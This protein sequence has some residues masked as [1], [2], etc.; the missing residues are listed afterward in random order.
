[1]MHDLE[2]ARH[3]VAEIDKQII[4]LIADRLDVVADL[5]KIKK[6]LNIPLRDW[7]VEKRVLT[8]VTDHAK[9]RGIS[10]ELARATLQL[11]IE[12]SRVRQEKLH[13]SGHRG[14]A[15]D[16]LIIG[17]AGTMGRWF[18]DFFLDQGH[19]VWVYDV[20]EES[21]D[22]P[23]VADLDTGLERTSLALIA[24]PLHT[25]PQT[26]DKLARYRFE[27]TV[28]DIASL[29]GHIK[30]SIAAAR[31]ANLSVASI[32]PMFGGGARTLS[33][34]VICCCDCGD[35]D[36]LTHV[37]SLFRNTAANLV[38]LTLDEH[39]EIISYVLGLSHLINVLF[40]TTLKNSGLSYRDLE[41]IGSTTFSSQMRTTS[42]VIRE[43]PDLYYDI[44]HLNPFTPQRLSGL[45]VALERIV[46]SI[47]EEQP[48]TFSSIMNAA[49]AWL[50][51]G[52]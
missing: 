50:D 49:R 37:E 18:A 32:H 1:M 3:K 6:E 34:K 23:T 11:L 33:D 28:F 52:D 8:R 46:S 2:A 14:S 19:R 15:E 35:A 16:I 44:Q 13:Y 51:A 39:D 48:S 21:K 12:E 41:R 7:E 42:T 27:G 25:V 22:Y 31:S 20:H 29:K 5:G 4:D 9:Q 45:K 30:E 40:A 38:R 10:S 43:N 26:Y 24:T 36:A 17:G 47:H